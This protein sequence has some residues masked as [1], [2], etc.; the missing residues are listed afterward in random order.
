MSDLSVLDDT[1][2]LNLCG[3]IFP[4]TPTREATFDELK[5]RA[6]ELPLPVL[7]ELPH[8]VSGKGLEGERS[9]FREVLELK[10]EEGNKRRDVFALYACLE[11]TTVP[12]R[13]EGDSAAQLQ[14]VDPV[15]IDDI[16]GNN[17]TIATLLPGYEARPQQVAMSRAVTTAF[18]E[19]KHLL[20]EAGTGVGKSLAYLV[21]AL[22]WGRRNA[23]PVLISTNTKNLQSQL[24]EKDIPLLRQ[25]AGEDFTA[26]VIKGRRNYLCLRKF[27]HLLEHG[28]S[29]LK[30]EQRIL[31]ASVLVW[32][33]VTQSGDLSECSMLSSP[34]AGELLDHITS[35]AGECPAADP[36]FRDRCFVQRARRKAQ[37]ADLVVANHAVI[38]SE[39]DAGDDGVVLPPYNHIIFDEAHNIE[40]AATTHLSVELSISRWG[41]LVGKLWKHSRKKEGGGIVGLVQKQYEGSGEAGVDIRSALA[42]TVDALRNSDM[43]AASF[44]DVYLGGTPGGRSGTVRLPAGVTDG[45]Q[46][47]R[48]QEVRQHLLQ[49]LMVLADS[50]LDLSESVKTFAEERGS[51][52]RDL[53]LRL[54]YSA[55]SVTAFRR[56]VEFVTD[57]SDANFVYWL[58][59][60]HKRNPGRVCAAPLLIGPLLTTMLFSRKQS[61]ILASATLSVMGNMNF[62]RERLGL[63]DEES[64]RVMEV[65]VGSPFD[66][67]AQCRVLVPTFL[68]EPGREE[69]DY[70]RHLGRL[71]AR[72]METSRGRALVL[73]TSYGLMEK[74]VTVYRLEDK[75]G[76]RLLVQGEAASREALTDMFRED[77]HSVLM[78]TQSFWE[79]VDV[80]GESLSCV[81]VTR[82]PFA[83]HTDPIQ[84][85][86]LEQLEK[87]GRPA[88]MQFSLPNALIRF[89]QGFGRLIR[90]RQDRGVVIVTDTRVFSKPYG[91][92]FRKSIPAP[93]MECE[94][95]EAFLAAINAAV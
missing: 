93:W 36:M 29:E 21:P 58:E 64:E 53:G 35:E 12:P 14:M 80:V 24:M 77:T 25:A 75:T 72:T 41:H 4:R 26:V 20:L 54:D 16:L 13:R 56:D 65:N 74:T 30:Q 60:G 11:P 73:F 90:H 94:N 9:F 39:L 91:R 10:G 32:L 49:S 78:G 46:L 3:I 86:R 62:I 68:P 19:G 84:E 61:V 45:S 85:A 44:F 33:V 15:E 18:N 69:G 23:V 37:A 31:V 76:Y 63:G 43:A 38:F 27:L 51:S 34:G 89:R 48:M 82:L 92:W 2:R 40:Q 50:M 67:E 8:I 71:L 87:D 17:G 81:V 47:A 55:E 6:G 59:H 66:Y 79:G 88:F 70:A 1:L 42:A 83:V 5:R 22:L 7:R 28:L 57:A 95:E 52:A